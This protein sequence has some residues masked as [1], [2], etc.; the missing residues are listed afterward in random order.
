MDGRTG[1]K[2]QN[3][4]EFTLTQRATSDSVIKD[5][6]I[7][8]KCLSMWMVSASEYDR[9]IWAVWMLKMNPPQSED[10]GVES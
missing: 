7:K 9:K 6:S 10:T 3:E 2:N 4:L 8:N 5:E 1:W